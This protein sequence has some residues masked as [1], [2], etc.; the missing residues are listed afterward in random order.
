MKFKLIDSQHIQRGILYIIFQFHFI[1]IIR[2]T[3]NI[4][5]GKKT[6]TN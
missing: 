5:K 1:P 6:K 4:I 3:K 2:E